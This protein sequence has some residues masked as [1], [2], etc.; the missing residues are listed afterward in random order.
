[1]IMQPQKVCI[2]TVVA[3]VGRL[4]RLSFDG[5]EEEREQWVDFESAD[6]FPIGWCQFFNYPLKPPQNY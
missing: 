3:V 1:M 6:I 5:Y 2:A 4:V